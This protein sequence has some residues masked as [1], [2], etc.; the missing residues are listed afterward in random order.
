MEV[1]DSRGLSRTMQ[2]DSTAGENA[3]E[4]FCRLWNA[5]L[6]QLVRSVRAAEF[7]T[8]LSVY[9]K[10]T[11]NRHYAALFES[12]EGG[13]NIG[14]YSFI[15]CEPDQ[16]WKCE[17]GK[18]T[19]ATLQ[20][21]NSFSDFVPLEGAPL[22]TLRSLI[23]EAQFASDAPVKLAGGLVGYL[24]YDAVRFME[25]LPD[26][27]KPQ[28]E[29]LPEG[30]FF[31][32]TL[33]AVFDR[34]GDRLTLVVVVR[35]QKGITAEQA[36]EQ[37]QARLASAQEQI[38]RPLTL[39]DEPPRGDSQS[40]RLSDFESNTGADKY[41][42]MVRRAKEYI[43]AGDIYQVVLSQKFCAETTMRGFDFY[44]ALRRHNPAPFLFFLNLPQAAVAGSSPEMLVRVEDGAL[45][46]RPLAGTRRRGSTDAEDTALARELLADEKERAEHLMLLDL[47][48]NDI[49]RV[50]AQGTVSVP[51]SFTVE[52]YSQVM[53]IS[54]TVT[55]RLAA[56]CDALDALISTFPAGTLSGAPKVRAMEIIE[57]LEVARRGLYGGAVGYF[58]AD[59]SLDSCIALRTA[60][61]EN[62]TITIQAGA[63]IV[64]DSD[65]Q[66]EQQECLNKA[67]ALFIAAQDAAKGTAKPE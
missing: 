38:D 50:A 55:G 59:G 27:G 36:W 51:R 61:L 15:V 6:P 53:H 16:V 44:R 57:E 60:V 32:P 12:V 28:S 3:F 30:L 4:E 14:R 7:E 2:G 63:G 11:E 58:G 67:R 29:A 45:T 46:T 18:A 40:V 48:R 49:G 26:A 34:I 66:A 10:L 9:L 37:A 13:V 17:G 41:K 43:R 19:Q 35:P 22:E 39:Q 56:G 64:G 21:D 24:S 25:S 23:A 20:S 52:R 33:T 62:G 5:G 54:S 65:E 1:T 8:P 31:R 47:G 42:A